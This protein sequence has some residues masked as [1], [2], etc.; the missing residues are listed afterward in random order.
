M[1]MQLGNIPQSLVPMSLEKKSPK[2]S[3]AEFEGRTPELRPR[4]LNAQFALRKQGKPVIVL[5]AGLDG[6]GKG[7]VIHRLNE[8]LDPRG[9]ETNAFLA[10]TEEEQQRPRFWR[11]WKAMPARDKMAIYYGSWY[12]GPILRRTNGSMS[13]EA[14]NDCLE[15]INFHERMLVQDGFLIVKIWLHVSRRTQEKRFNR[16]ADK[17]QDT[18]W[19]ILPLDWEHFS[20]YEEFAEVSSAVIEATNSEAAPWT[21]VPAKNSNYRDI[22][23]GEA[24]AQAMENAADKA[25]TPAV[26]APETDISEEPNRVAVGE[27]LS[28]VDLTQ[29]LEKKDY[30]EQLKLYQD[31]L[32]RLVMQA[33]QEKVPSVLVFEGWDAAGKGSAIRRVTNAIDPRLCRTV[34][35]AAPTDEEKVHHYLWRFWRHLPAGG[36][37]TIYDRSWYGRVLVERMEGYA[38]GPEWRRAFSEIKDFEEQ[39]I[40]HGTIVGK[41][42]LQI[43][44]DEQLRRFNKRT[45]TA[46]K[47]HKITDEDWRN[48]EKWDQYE[49]AIND[50]V[51]MTSTEKLPWTLVAGNDKK[52]ARISILK[53]VCRL[54]EARMNK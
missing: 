28:Q 1:D 49:D 24:I 31:R 39:L 48:R 34:P 36:R 19:Q 12:T 47:Q 40:E 25:T 22:A 54:F 8:W 26:V 53:E 52:F 45:N 41:F 50:M 10:K 21:I 44:P 42:W 2:L 4:L 33:W 11:Y 43:S 46:W 35:I 18:R 32:N 9:V 51:G 38:T 7:E 5:V 13:K 23:V 16:I 20:Q 27:Y 15:R 3:K 6:A 30:S 29:R 37:M 17:T 14:L